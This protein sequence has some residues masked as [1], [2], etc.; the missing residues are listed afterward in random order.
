[1]DVEVHAFNQVLEGRGRGILKL[2]ASLNYRA[3]SRAKQKLDIW[4]RI[5]GS[6]L[7]SG[8]QNLLQLDL[9]LKMSIIN[10]SVG[11]LTQDFVH[12]GQVSAIPLQDQTYDV[13]EAQRFLLCKDSQLGDLVL[14]GFIWELCG[15]CLLCWGLNSLLQVR[16]RFDLNKML[17]H[18]V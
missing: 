2:E 3:S 9:S 13:A 4:R 5:R 1:M 10:C 11:V 8:F 14:G 16:G 7:V 15:F 12:S 18:C 17:C 6:G